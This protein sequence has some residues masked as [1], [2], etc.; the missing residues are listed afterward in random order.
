MWAFTTAGIKDQ[1]LFDAIAAEALIKIAEFNTQNLSNTIWAFATAGVRADK[2]FE[3]IAGKAMRKNG[4][5]N[6]QEMANTI[7]S[8]ACVGWKQSQIFREIGTTLA[9][10][11][12]ELN[13]AGRSQLYLVTLYVQMEW[14]DM[15][16]PLSSHVDALRTA[17]ERDEPQP[18]RLQRDISA[19]LKDMGWPHAFEHFT[20]EGI[21]LD[22]ADP[23]KKRAIEVDG[24]SHFLKDI[25]TGK[26][27]PN[28]ATEF[29]S[30]ILH[31]YDWKVAHVPF[32]AWYDKSKTER[33]QFL[34]ARLTEIGV[35]HKLI[36]DAGVGDRATTEVAPRP[37]SE[38][39]GTAG[40]KWGTGGGKATFADVLKKT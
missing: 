3:V 19:M 1:I 14:P 24:P 32:F 5:F 21:S 16:F 12:P 27:V 8:L 37:L 33:R 35:R 20:A 36:T 13:E 40:N 17:Y 2:L 23:E 7:Y 11:F 9:E 4:E 6:L 15:K 29:K 26:Y 10:R 34:G 30:R 18:S 22:L 28:G 38:P 39:R 31:R 25:T